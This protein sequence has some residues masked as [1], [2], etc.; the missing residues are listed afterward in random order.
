MNRRFS[1]NNEL[2][3][4]LIYTIVIISVLVLAGMCD[5][6]LWVNALF[7]VFALFSEVFMIIITYFERF[8]VM[9]RSI[10]MSVS[11]IILC[12]YSFSAMGINALMII[13]LLV[14]CC[15]AA[16]YGEIKVNIILFLFSF[17][18]A[19]TSFLEIYPRI[20]YVRIVALGSM[21]IG[22]II[23][24]IM[25]AKNAKIERQNIYRNRSNSDLL[26]LVEIKKMDAESATKAKAD[27][28]ASMSHEI[29][30]PMNAIC[31][32]SDLLTQTELTP[33]ASDY[34]KTIKS[35]ADNLLG[36][37]NDIL[38]FSKIESGMLDL[39]DS[40]YELKNTLATLQNVVNTRIGNRNII[41]LVHVNPKLPMKLFGDELR[42]H[43][44]LL[45]LLTN[46]VKFTEAGSIILTIDYEMISSSQLMLKF[47]V[48]DTGIGIKE[49]DCDKLFGAFTQVDMERNR[50]VEGT[51]LGLAITSR[52]AKQ[53]HGNISVKSEY[54]S[55]TTF[56]VEIVQDI[57]DSTPCDAQLLSHRDRVLHIL[58]DNGLYRDNVERM[59]NDL[60]VPYVFHKNDKWLTRALKNQKREIVIYDYD[61]YHDSILGICSDNRNVLFVGM[62]SLNQVIT[63]SEYDNVCYLHNP[64]TM[65]SIIPLVVGNIVK[66]KVKRT[67]ISPFYAPDARVLVV[68]DTI[69]NLKVAEG[70]MGQYKMNIV[71]AQSGREAI[72]MLK[73]DHDFDMLFIDHMMPGMDGI[74]L[75]KRLRAEQDDFYRMIPIVAL[76]ANAI[77]GM[78]EMFLKNG[79]DGFLPKPINIKLLA[80]IL[81]K[82]LPAKKQIAKDEYSEGQD[83]A[84]EFTSDFETVKTAFAA[85]RDFDLLEALA[86]CDGKV[87]ILFSVIK[88]YV[89]GYTAS[90]T[91]LEEYLATG[92]V[93]N[94]GIEAHGL[95]SSSKS[96]GAIE[97]SDYAKTFEM[98]CKNDNWEY[99]KDNH[100][101]F[102]TDY[103]KIIAELSNIFEKLAPSA[104]GSGEAVSEEELRTV[105]LEVRALLEE[106][107]SESSLDKMNDLLEHSFEPDMLK[108]LEDIRDSIDT[109]DYSIATDVIDEILKEG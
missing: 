50:N 38:D 47:W 12:G 16:L 13:A 65:F 2:T 59:L 44:I 80:E 62:V 102:L 98:A 49:E 22:E 69:A 5:V 1:K 28:L 88:V 99:V 20:E 7:S 86:L 53:M 57:A 21:L 66:S 64:L 100:S 68:D 25:L 45:N 97:F 51:G 91:R 8:S 75:V 18:C 3:V 90:R 19:I 72:E 48:S 40:E 70:L 33:I 67:E 76:T 63:E 94:Y 41:F 32:M 52:L 27:F 10:F 95:K 109:F 37:I 60:K 103:D 107:D 78:E 55:G 71:T 30:T 29:R 6:P 46:A 105:L 92:D 77:K 54:G 11:L 35:S 108:R 14:V 87:E 93:K 15:I 96:I 17:I 4:L 84:N 85:Y 81:H 56:Y 61:S 101:A 74:E 106:W 43:Q 31:G 89:K 34:V 82:W 24:V 104:C 42:V 58:L 23:L 36:I 73:Q 79:F 9:F 39:I 83:M 26:R